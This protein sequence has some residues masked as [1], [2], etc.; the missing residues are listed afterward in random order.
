MLQHHLLHILLGFRAVLYDT[1]FMKKLPGII[2]SFLKL[3]NNTSFAACVTQ[4]RV[5]SRSVSCVLN[6]TTYLGNNE[7]PAAGGVVF[8][9]R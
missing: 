4:R 9:R 2:D 5:Y 6:F 1:V 7:L 3:L 8:F